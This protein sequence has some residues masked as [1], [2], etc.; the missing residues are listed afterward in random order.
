MV[1]RL[2]LFLI[3]FLTSFVCAQT[4]LFVSEKSGQAI[5]G[6]QIFCGSNSLGVTNSRGEVELPS[7]CK[8]IIIHHPGYYSEEIVPNQTRVELTAVEL[9]EKLIDVV[10]ISDQSDP[11]ALEILRESERRFKQ[12]SP[13]SLDS[14]SFKVYEKLSFDFPLDSISHYKN[15]L[16]LQEKQ[17]QRRDF[18]FQTKRQQKDSIR[19]QKIKS[20]LAQSKGF[21]WE[22]VLERKFDAH[23]GEKTIVIDSKIS[24][25]KEPNYPLLALGLDLE[26]MPEI[27]K[28]EN[29]SL[30]R[31]YLSDTL[32]WEGRE[33]FVIQ[34]V[35]RENH[36]PENRRKFS[37][38][39]LIDQ[40]TY[41][42][43]QIESRDRDDP[44]GW[45]HQ[46][47]E[48]LEGKWFPKSRVRYSRALS[49][50]I[51]N[52]ELEN[53]SLKVG[54]YGLH[55][56]HYFEHRASI[57]LDKKEMK[58]YELEINSYGG[59]QLSNYRIRPLTQ[60]ETLSYAR[61]DS[62]STEKS[63]EEK[64]NFL[65]TLTR[66]RIRWGKIDF[67]PSRMFQLNQYEWLRLGVGVKLNEKVHPYISPDA[68]LAYG[69]RDKAFKYGV[70]VDIRTS[71]SWH[72]VF[73]MEYYNDALVGGHFSENLWNGRMKLMNS[74]ANLANKNFISTKGFA[75]SYERDLGRDFTMRLLMKKEQNEALFDY[76]FKGLDTPFNETA[77]L[78]SL[79]YA[80]YTEA[81]MAP[82]GQYTYKTGYPEIYLNYE[83]GLSILKGESEYDRLDLLLS[84]QFKNKFGRTGVRLHGGKLWGEVPVWH[85]F[86]MMGLSKQDARLK[87]ELTSYLGLATLPGGKYYNDEFFGYYFT[88][89]IPWYFKSFGKHTS[90][91]EVLYRGAIGTME[92]PGL[93]DFEFEPMKKLYQ[94]VG[95]EWNN[96]LSSRFNLGFFYRVGHYRTA[97]FSENFAIQLKLRLLGF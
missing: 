21:L 6:A 91:F 3:L 39:L 25:L 95:I 38:R 71:L 9:K 10:Q 87:F 48:L 70:G 12:N 52:D 46:D 93:H 60:R 59:E 15:H 27:L 41:A 85:N 5:E 94:E 66:G 44:N 79:K 1:K 78:V 97:S 14:Y 37:G 64:A 58:G 50:N 76:K 74:G 51:S 82:Y 16:E 69:F 55:E 65:S 28:R 86:Q 36:R 42:L 83:K 33:T 29:S 23:Y 54:Y 24:G 45:I 73:R 47:W 4:K 77:A 81:L 18:S 49:F 92:N 43:R 2:S 20:F 31:F 75:M 30:Y 61:I 80:P 90:S 62:L 32:N 8:R 35:Q 67:L 13:Q 17:N 7:L 84:H 56:T 63:L 26:K 68:F 11:R 88:H 53:D 34:Y 72:S 57:A 96:F 19:K 89:Q 22:R 40:K